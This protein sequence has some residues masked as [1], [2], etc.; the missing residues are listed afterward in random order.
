MYDSMAAM[1]TYISL[2]FVKPASK[3]WYHNHDVT[4]RPYLSKASL[5]YW[6]SFF[7]N[8]LLT[9]LDIFSLPAEERKVHF[10]FARFR[11]K[12]ATIPNYPS[13]LL[14]PD[15]L[16][17]CMSEHEIV[18]IFQGR[19]TKGR[20]IEEVIRVLPNKINRKQVKLILKGAISGSYK[21]NLHKIISDIHVEN[22]VEF[23]GV[24]SYESVPFFTSKCHIGL[25]I[26]TGND[27]MNSTLGTAS[28]KAYEYIACGLPFLYFDNEHFRKYF[29][30][31]SWA[32]PTDLST[33]SLIE[34]I[35]KIDNDYKL[36]SLAAKRD[37][38]NSR[39]YEN[40]FSP[41]MRLLNA[42]GDEHIV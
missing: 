18:I 35:T 14:Y 39:N 10:N 27:V 1:A 2:R 9:D 25:A 24:S 12:Y 20:G 23:F 11:G 32:F 6:S 4:Y 21:S 34:K 16:I 26:F 38:I 33:D 3:L 15:E 30:D 5:L 13:K 28:N 7:E 42:E 17:S 8:K 41:V 29:K 19:I 22:L 36:L 31:M 37:F 40:V